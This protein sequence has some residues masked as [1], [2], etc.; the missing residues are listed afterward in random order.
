MIRRLAFTASA[1]AALAAAAGVAVVA[2]AF[3]LYALLVEALRPAGA[4]AV[5]AAIAALIALVGALL[6]GRKGSPPPREEQG[7]AGRLLDIAR[8]RPVLAAAAAVATGVVALRNPK[9]M[10]AVVSAFVAGRTAKH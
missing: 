8:E 7:P 2:A 9:I 4:A 6:M 5:V 10:A 3:A 1:V